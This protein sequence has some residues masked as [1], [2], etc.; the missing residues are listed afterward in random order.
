MATTKVRLARCTNDHMALNPYRESSGLWLSLPYTGNRDLYYV[1]VSTFFCT[2]TRKGF[3]QRRTFLYG[4]RTNRL[5]ERVAP[6][7]IALL[8]PMTRI[9]RETQASGPGFHPMV[10]LLPVEWLP[11]R[12]ST[13]MYV[14]ANMSTS[15][16][17]K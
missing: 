13:H 8:S 11:L 5:V 1:M 2:L 15:A 3:S 14:C 12:R 6:N 9:S 10:I 17:T 16:V 4:P 7:V